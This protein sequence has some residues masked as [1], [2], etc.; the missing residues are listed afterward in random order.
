MVELGC[1]LDTLS[2]GEDSFMKELLEA[3]AEL[4]YDARNVQALLKEDPS[5]RTVSF[6]EAL[7]WS[8]DKLNKED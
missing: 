4:G 2:D 8:I 6:E 7:R 3:C 5:W 1:S